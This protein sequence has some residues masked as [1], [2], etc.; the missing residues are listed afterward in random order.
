MEDE[1]APLLLLPSAASTIVLDMEE[2]WANNSR[3]WLVCRTPAS[4]VGS[5]DGL[6]AGLLMGAAKCPTAGVGAGRGVVDA[7]AA[8][9]KRA[10][11]ASCATDGEAGK[12]GARLPAAGPPSLRRLSL[13]RRLSFSRSPS[14]RPF[15][16][17]QSGMQALYSCCPSIK[18]ATPQP[19]SSL[20][21][22]PKHQV[23]STQHPRHAS[24]L[25]LLLSSRA[26]PRRAYS[27][28]LSDVP[29]SLSRPRLQ[30]AG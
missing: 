13:M 8:L 29:F 23:P 10:R 22:H 12:Q 17:S 21:P 2:A 1:P 25:V 3:L 7:S 14:C 6:Q 26:Y 18:N 9:G 28:A 24:L 27:S 30:L 4:H 19:P 11:S 15:R 16:A 20:I 5:A